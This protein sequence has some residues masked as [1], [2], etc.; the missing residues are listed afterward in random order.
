MEIVVPANFLGRNLFDEDKKA[1]CRT[2]NLTNPK[3][4]YY[5]WAKVC[6]LLEEGN[7]SLEMG[8]ENYKRYA[9]IR[10]K[11]KDND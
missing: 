7:Y 3:G 6:S 10:S 9:I 1:L 2:L 4:G 11:P 5:K 8:R